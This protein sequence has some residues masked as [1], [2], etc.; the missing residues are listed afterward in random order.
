MQIFIEGLKDTEK[1][2]RWYIK[3]QTS[4]SIV[5]NAVHLF[6]SAWRYKYQ[7]I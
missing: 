7:H 2:I 5:I 4:K 1:G 3:H 6:F